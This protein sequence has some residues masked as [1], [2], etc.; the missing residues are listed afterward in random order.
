MIIHT[1]KPL[2]VRDAIHRASRSRDCVAQTLQRGS[3]KRA[4]SIHFSL[5]GNGGRHTTRCNSGNWGAGSENAAH[6]DDW[7]V[8]IAAVFE[9]DP[10]ASIPRVYE[11]ADDFHRITNNRFTGPFDECPGSRHNWVTS[12][13]TARMRSCKKCSAVQNFN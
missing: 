9:A 12:N 1:D 4:T 6:W 3:R 2:E 13:S 5:A 10:N 7:G 11:T 8:V